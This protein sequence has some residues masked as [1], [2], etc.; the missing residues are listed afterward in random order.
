MSLARVLKAEPV[1]ELIKDNESRGAVEAQGVASE[2]DVVGG[3]IRTEDR[4]QNPISKLRVEQV[5]FWQDIIDP[6]YMSEA[7]G[8]YEIMEDTL[9]GLAF[10]PKALFNKA[11]QDELCLQLLDRR[12]WAQVE[13]GL[14]SVEAF[15]DNLAKEW[16]SLPVITGPNRGKSYYAGDGLNK[17]YEK[18]ENVIKAIKAALKNKVVLPD[19]VPV[20]DSPEAEVVVWLMNAPPGVELRQ[21]G[22]WLMEMPELA[23]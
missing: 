4:T 14:M 22:R 6:L 5:L 17:A 19:E 3:G 23:A 21:L 16:A 20:D 8:A 12:G 10:N 1:M 13:K 9:R 2:Y 18:P 11:T 15:G 7:V